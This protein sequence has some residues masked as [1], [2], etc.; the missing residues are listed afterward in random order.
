MALNNTQFISSQFCRS[1]VSVVLLV[2][3]LRSSEGQNQS[4]GQAG[5]LL[6]ALNSE[7]ESAMKPAQSIDKL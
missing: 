6:E 7:E 4:V 2:S 5:F 1:K 3:L